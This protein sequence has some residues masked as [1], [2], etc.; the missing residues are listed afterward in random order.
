MPN[1]TPV[2]AASEGR[3][4]EQI[5]IA[6][7]EREAFIAARGFNDLVS[8]ADRFRNHDP[9]ECVVVGNQ[10]LLHVRHRCLPRARRFIHYA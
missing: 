10:D 4:Q 7:G 1:R 2:C 3:R 5:N 9:H 6:T 8:I